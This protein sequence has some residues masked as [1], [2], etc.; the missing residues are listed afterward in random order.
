MWNTPS[1]VVL[2]ISCLEY[3]KTTMAC[4][5]PPRGRGVNSRGA[6]TG[7]PRSGVVGPSRGPRDVSW[8]C[9]CAS[10]CAA[11]SYTVTKHELWSERFDWVGP[12]PNWH[13]RSLRMCAA[14]SRCQFKSQAQSWHKRPGVGEMHNA[15][16]HGIN[17]V[18]GMNASYTR[19]IS[20]NYDS[21]G[22][23]FEMCMWLPTKRTTH[24]ENK[25]TPS[26]CGPAFQSS[27]APFCTFAPTVS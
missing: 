13:E 5:G 25:L 1:K 26:I 2:S 9:G 6:G 10:Y 19:C 17:S 12:Q 4:V 14:Q 15:K 3:V 16:N 7:G 24:M 23:K 21:H 11:P 18:P 20:T 27:C 8:L 22:K